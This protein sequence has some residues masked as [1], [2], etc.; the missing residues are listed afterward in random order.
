MYNVSITS[1][2]NPNLYNG[3][4]VCSLLTVMSACSVAEK[5]GLVKWLS[6][7]F[8]KLDLLNPQHKINTEISKYDWLLTPGI[9][10]NC[11]I[12]W[13]GLELDSGLQ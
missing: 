8:L 2:D 9:P 1:S 10:V 3:L 7:H 6:D 5:R 11:T 13:N 12:T 4:S